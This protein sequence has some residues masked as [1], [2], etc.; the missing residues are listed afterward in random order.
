[1]VPSAA[2]GQFLGGFIAKKMKLSIPGLIRLCIVGMT[3]TLVTVAIVWIDC[4][5][6]DFVGV[7]SHY[8]NRLA[9][10]LLFCFF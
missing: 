9:L 6:E 8:P 2:S 3:L 5:Q 10:N 1:V 4:G 7:T